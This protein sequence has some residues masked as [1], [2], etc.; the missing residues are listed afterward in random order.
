MQIEDELDLP[1]KLKV[2]TV[3][4]CIQVGTNQLTYNV[5]DKAGN[6]AVSQTRTVTVTD[7]RKPIILLIG[8]NMAIE[9]GSTFTD[10]GCRVL[11]E[12]CLV[13]LFCSLQKVANITIAMQRVLV[14]IVFVK[15]TLID[16]STPL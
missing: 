14:L 6:A 9:A 8:S 10:P 4:T 11:D 16:S 5:K 3:S 2:L 13:T 7:T 15:I 12:V 1:C